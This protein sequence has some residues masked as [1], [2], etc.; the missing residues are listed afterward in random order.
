MI[1]TPQI[2]LHSNHEEY[3]VENKYDDT[4]EQCFKTIGIIS[5][6]V[7]NKKK[8]SLFSHMTNKSPHF[9]EYSMADSF[10]LR[11]RKVLEEGLVSLF[12]P[13]PMI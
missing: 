7:I 3:Q 12:T 1:H 8:K 9:P 4:K 6:N 13:Y 2:R 10:V 11:Q 5:M